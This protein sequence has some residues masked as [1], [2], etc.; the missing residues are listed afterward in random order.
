MEY[1]KLAHTGF[2]ISRIGFGC[3][4]IGGH[5]Y[6]N[7]DDSESEKSIKKALDCGINFFDT[8]DVY[9]FGHSEKVLGKALGSRKNEVIV[10]TKFGVAWDKKG[11]TYKDCSPKQIVRALEDS[12][13]RLKMDCIPLYQI[14]WHDGRTPIDDIMDTLLKCRKAGKLRYVGCCNFSKGMLKRARCNDEIATFQCLFNIADRENED[15][16]KYA[17]KDLGISVLVYSVMGRGVFSAKYDNNAIFGLN[18]TRNKDKEFRGARFPRN[19]F[20]AS[21]LKEIGKRYGKTAA[22]TVI[23]WV[24]ENPFITC[25]IIGIKNESQAFE[26]ANSAGWFLKQEDMDLIDSLLKEGGL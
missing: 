20:Y 4:A 2:M 15:V 22:Q 19:I 23:R 14:H 17:S 8:A 13:R 25:A 10:A 1:K 24:L 18:D 6:G 12:L 7:V 26:N 11:K 16:I 21:K 3:W 5:G 9:G